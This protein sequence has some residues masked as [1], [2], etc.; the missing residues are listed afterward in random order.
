M[1]PTEADLFRCSEKSV[2]VCTAVMNM[3]IMLEEFSPAGHGAIRR[4]PCGRGKGEYL[5]EVRLVRVREGPS[6]LDVSDI[7]VVVEVRH[8]RH[9][10]A[11]KLHIT[12][13]LEDTLAKLT[14]STHYTSYHEAHTGHR[15]EH[16]FYQT[17]GPGP[18]S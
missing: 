14:H 8:K 10:E 15:T 1:T 12:N 9:L 18:L 4:D 2:S 5:G 16:S 6:R 3:Y 7:W 17:T 11:A 13:M